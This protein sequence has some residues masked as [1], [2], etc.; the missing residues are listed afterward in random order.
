MKKPGKARFHTVRSIAVL[1]CM[2]MFLQSSAL[3]SD[4]YYIA[5]MTQ[6]EWDRHYASLRDDNTLPTLCVGA[7]ETQ[8]SLVW[9]ANASTAQAKLLLAD[10]SDMRNPKTFTGTLTPAETDNQLVCRVTITGL[11]QNSVYYYQY[12]ADGGLSKPYEY[13]TGSFENFKMLVI[14]DIQIGGQT[15]GNFEEQSRIGYAWQNLL[16]EALSKNPDTAFLLSPGDNTST[17][18]SPDEWQTL[19]M[20]ETLRSLPLALAIG[21]HDKKGFSYNYYTNMPNEFYGKYFEELDRDFWFRYGDALILV[22][23]ATSGSAADHEAMAKQAVAANKDAKWRLAV[24]HQAPYAPGFMGFAPE[25]AILLNGVFRPIFNKYN[26]DLVLTGHTHCQ[27]RSHFISDGV[28][29]GKAKSGGTYE[30]PKG[31]IYLN[32][33]AVCNQMGISSAL[34]PTTAYAFEQDDVPTYTSID[35]SSG[36]MAVKTYRG[37]NS[38]LLDSITIKKSDGYDDFTFGDLTNYASYFIVK[39]LGLIYMRIDKVVVSIRGGHF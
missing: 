5:N 11:E 27:G 2:I 37:D 33:N 21:N 22:F 13:R 36:E 35:F 7:D 15:S 6:E 32:S 10:N 19:L 34:N 39:I 29:V 24:M 18:K 30:N 25:T 26:V 20:P 3:F 8:V 14:G 31:I 9:H 23:D 28:V 4:A 12:F 1:L 38:E 16:D 17:G